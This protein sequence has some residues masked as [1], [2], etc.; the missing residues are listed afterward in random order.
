MKVTKKTKI[1]TSK[2]FLK[3]DNYISM[4]YKYMLL[5]SNLLQCFINIQL[6]L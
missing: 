6:S 2:T 5:H 1:P 3:T 4:T